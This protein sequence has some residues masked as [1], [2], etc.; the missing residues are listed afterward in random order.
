LLGKTDQYQ[1][2]QLQLII[3][4]RHSSY[5]NTPI[6]GETNF[7]RTAYDNDKI[8]QLPFGGNFACHKNF[9]LNGY[10]YLCSNALFLKVHGMWDGTAKKLFKFLAVQWEMNS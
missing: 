1:H 3:D 4:W 6:R 10:P 9:M 8:F 5:L 2:G 7:R